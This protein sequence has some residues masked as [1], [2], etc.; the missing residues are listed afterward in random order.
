MPAVGRRSRRDQQGAPRMDKL[1]SLSQL[2]QHHGPSQGIRGR[3][4][5]DPPAQTTQDQ[6]QRRRVRTISKRGFVQRV[7]TLQGA[8]DGWLDECACLAVKDIGKP[9]AGKPHAR[10]DEGGLDLSRKRLVR[11]CQP[12]GAATD[13]PALNNSAG[14]LLYPLSPLPLSLRG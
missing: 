6:G 8:D 13:M 11:H 7:R 1:F 10:F 4:D 14:P 5:S 2:Q 9:C 12:K 3:T